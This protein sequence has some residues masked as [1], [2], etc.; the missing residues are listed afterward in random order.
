MIRMLKR[1]ADWLDNRFPAK[2]HVTDEAFQ[3]LL[4]S[5]T[6]RTQRANTQEAE[7]KSIN[8]SMADLVERVE[9]LSSFC[10]RIT[11]LLDD[12]RKRIDLLEG[13]LGSIKEVVTKAA[14]PDAQA[15]ARRASFV[16]SGRMPE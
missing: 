1:F 2:V 5:E 13:T 11:V 7:V 10:G 4:K 8:E 14:K 12:E 16:E 3:A 6:E 15:A 9:S